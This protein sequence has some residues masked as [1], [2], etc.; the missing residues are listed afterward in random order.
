MG[1]TTLPAPA[2]SIVRVEPG[3]CSAVVGLQWGDEGK[4]KAVDL[5]APAHDGVVRYN[6]GANAGHSVVVGGER[7]ALHLVPSGILTPGKP[8]VIANG[9][10]VDPGALLAELEKL[11]ARGVDTS[12][13]VV[14]DRAHVVVEYHKAEDAIR[15]EVLAGWH[16]VS[17]AGAA[18]RAHDAAAPGSSEIGT[19]KRGIGPCYGE[20]V[21]R[22]TAV[23]MGDLLRPEALREKL[24]LACHFK[25]AALAGLKPGFE[26]FDAGVLA[27]GLLECGRRLG[28]RI[29]DTTYLLHEM[30]RDGKRLLFEGANAT[31][32]DVDHGTYPFVTASGCAV[33]GIGAGTGVPERRIDHVL[34]VVKAYSSRVG[35]GPM[36]TELRDD[37]GDRIRERGRE[38]GTTTGRPRRIGWLD[39]V[40]VRYSAMLNGVTGL[41]VTLLDVLEGLDELR[42]CTAYRVDGRTTERFIPDGAGL[43]RA[44]PVYQTLPG[45]SG[46]I[47]GARRLAD[48]PHA[49]LRYLDLIAEF[50][51]APIRLVGVGPGRDQTVIVPE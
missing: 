44:E 50:T 46:D 28:P 3:R 9:V 16:G 45:F 13:L 14:S 42:V 22:S 29:R 11:E 18:G 20:K 39:L 12:G 30:L 41:V 27:A 33:L 7:Y 31:L 21:Q 17:G 8:A 40:A 35:R 47:S 43:A 1:T 5:L 26:P 23:R 2:Q 49:A 24:R 10:A 34:G 48:L 4:G 51:E 38:Y 15:E 25:N 19:T 36:P 32:L 6:G 37:T